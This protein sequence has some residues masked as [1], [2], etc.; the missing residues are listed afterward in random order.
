[1]IFNC[2][3]VGN[4]QSKIPYFSASKTGSTAVFRINRQIGWAECADFPEVIL[5]EER[6][7]GVGCGRETYREAGSEQS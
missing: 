5:S 1:M 4:F 2:S 7:S 6:D 3:A